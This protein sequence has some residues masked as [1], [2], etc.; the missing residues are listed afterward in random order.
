MRLK[1]IALALAASFVLA[2]APA[3]AQVEKAPPIKDSATLTVTHKKAALG[4][5]FSVPTDAGTYRAP[6]LVVLSVVPANCYD[7]LCAKFSVSH[8]SRVDAGASA[9]AG[10]IA[11]TQVAV[12]KYVAL[13]TDTG[14]PVKTDVACPA[15]I[16]TGGLARQAGT[17]G[18]YTAP[19]TLNGAASYQFTSSW[20]S[21][22]SFTIAK[23][24][25]LNAASG[26]TLG[27]E[28]LLG[29]PVAVANGDT[30]NLTWTFNV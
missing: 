4:G 13:S 20:T 15:E 1:A 2:L 16:T 17:Y 3:Y 27:F 18:S 25:M 12:F 22:A 14:T 30:I 29:S 7:A 8:N 21:T 11:N 6:N 26:V 5:T 24:C 10:N 9:I 23:I 28:T 19:V